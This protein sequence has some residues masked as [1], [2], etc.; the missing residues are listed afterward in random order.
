M[1]YKEGDH[2]VGEIYKGDDRI[3]AV[4][5][6]G[7]TKNETGGLQFDVVVG[8]RPSKLEIGDDCRL[9]TEDGETKVQVAS[10]STL[11]EGPNQATFMMF[12][13]AQPHE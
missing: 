3:T 6:G 2:I 8:G 9:V 7:V 12:A 1:N 10:M 13:F 5:F 4:K 11:G